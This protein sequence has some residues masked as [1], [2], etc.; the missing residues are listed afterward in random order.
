MMIHLALN[1]IQKYEQCVRVIYLFIAHLF[2]SGT[3]GPE[4]QFS[5][6]HANRTNNKN[7]LQ[8]ATTVKFNPRK[9]SYN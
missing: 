4:Y 1:L 5:S 2:K 9:I 8:V 3:Q 7:D 6:Q